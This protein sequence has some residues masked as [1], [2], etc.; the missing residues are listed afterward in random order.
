MSA[1]QN[2]SKNN[3]QICVACTHVYVRAMGACARVCRYAL[4][5]QWNW[6]REYTKVY[7]VRIPMGGLSETNPSHL[8]CWNASVLFFLYLSLSLFFSLSHLNFGR[9]FL[10]LIHTCNTPQKCHADGKPIRANQ[11]HFISAKRAETRDAFH[12]FLHAAISLCRCV[13]RIFDYCSNSLLNY[14]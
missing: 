2:Y 5:V 11:L 13:E 12:I 7:E 9:G 8:P 4:G 14:I 1:C 10:R 3:C 6:D